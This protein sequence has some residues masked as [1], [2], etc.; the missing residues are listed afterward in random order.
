M[1][2]I[3]VSIVNS[4]PFFSFDNYGIPVI[5]G[6]PTNGETSKIYHILSM[7]GLLDN[8]VFT[9]GKGYV[10]PEPQFVYSSLRKFDDDNERLFAAN[11][12]DEYNTMMET[13]CHLIER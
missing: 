8:R 11:Y 2:P 7:A 3:V 13:V 6:K 10:Q 5:N 4:I 9:L 12:L 1:H